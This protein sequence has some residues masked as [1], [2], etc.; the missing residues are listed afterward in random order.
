VGVSRI[1][2]TPIKQIRSAQLRGF[3]RLQIFA[4]ALRLSAR[5]NHLKKDPEHS[6]LRSW[7]SKAYATQSS[8][9]GHDKSGEWSRRQG[10]R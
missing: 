8:Q 6:Q 9:I 3:G 7:W 10:D 2:Q 1:Q 4:A 5:A